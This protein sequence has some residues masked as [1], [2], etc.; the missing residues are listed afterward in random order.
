MKKLLIIFAFATFILGSCR[1]KKTETTEVIRE[2]H[3]EKVDKTNDAPPRE[4]AFERAAKK[5][6]QKVNDKI[7]EKID[8]LD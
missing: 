1:E 3:V 7:D 4:G 5:V 8:E 2:V 6:D